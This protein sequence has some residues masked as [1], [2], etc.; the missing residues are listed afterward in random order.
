M[1]NIKLFID[2][3]ENTNI[4]LYRQKSKSNFSLK[5]KS[6][7]KTNSLKS[8]VRIVTVGHHA[9]R[10]APEEDLDEVLGNILPLFENRCLQ[11]RKCRKSWSLL[12]NE[13]KRFGSKI[14]KRNIKNMFIYFKYFT[15]HLHTI[16][17]YNIN[18]VLTS[19][20]KLSAA[21]RKC[22]RKTKILFFTI[23]YP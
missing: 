18:K 10:N 3:I 23:I 8:I 20:Q 5:L 11:L 7:R 9:P 2:K 6:D 22:K 13:S 4:N 21:K 14:S 19:K 16:L 17:K 1:V 12:F 15:W